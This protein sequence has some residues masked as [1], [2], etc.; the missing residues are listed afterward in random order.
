MRTN[1]TSMFVI[2]VSGLCIYV[3]M[4]VCELVRWH[5]QQ[6]MKSIR[7]SL[8]KFGTTQ[9]ELVQTNIDCDIAH[10]SMSYRIRSV[11]SGKIRN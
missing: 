7:S 5:V 2:Y 11:R 4:C 8:L 3:S 1:A 6:I 9:S 10:Q